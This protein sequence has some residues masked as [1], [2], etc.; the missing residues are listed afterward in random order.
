MGADGRDAAKRGRRAEQRSLKAL[1]QVDIMC[2]MSSFAGGRFLAGG[3][4]RQ[5]ACQ[6]ATSDKAA[7][8]DVPR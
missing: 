7:L 2:V 8:S 4:R 1:G 6:K 5:P 3:V